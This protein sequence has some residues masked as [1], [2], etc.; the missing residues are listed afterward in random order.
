MFLGF[1]EFFQIP[2]EEV[3]DNVFHPEKFLKLAFS[4]LAHRILKKLKRFP[5]KLHFHVL[6]MKLLL[7]EEAIDFL[8]FYGCL[9]NFGRISRISG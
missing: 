8:S 6:L 4:I 9:S 5:V 1:F 2:L 3:L 7:F